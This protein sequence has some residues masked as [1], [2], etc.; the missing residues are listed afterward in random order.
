MTETKDG[1]FSSNRLKVHYRNRNSATLVFESQ[2]TGEITSLI[3][4]L[5]ASVERQKKDLDG[6][7]NFSSFHYDYSRYGV[8]LSFEVTPWWWQSDV[9]K[10]QIEGGND[11]GPEE[12]PNDSINALEFVFDERFYLT[13]LTF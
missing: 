8:L 10:E 7:G 13:D 9:P 11:Q 5:A 3:L 6:A 2:N 4:D 1:H 12:D